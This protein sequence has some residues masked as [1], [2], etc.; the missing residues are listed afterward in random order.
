MKLVKGTLKHNQNIID[1][2]KKL[3]IIFWEIKKEFFFY[4]SII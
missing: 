4:I 1:N 3:Y 2:F